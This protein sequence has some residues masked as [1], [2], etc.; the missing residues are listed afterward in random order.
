MYHSGVD[1]FD[2]RLGLDEFGYREPPRIRGNPLPHDMAAEDVQYDEDK[3]DPP[4]WWTA[5]G[6]ASPVTPEARAMCCAPV[7]TAQVRRDVKKRRPKDTSTPGV[8]EES[9]TL[10]LQRPYRFAPL[11]L[12]SE[13]VRL[14]VESSAPQ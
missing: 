8:A 1:E 5:P 4:L 14:A 10:Q 12:V 7:A 2:D 11:G 13:I 6:Q 9:V 3:H